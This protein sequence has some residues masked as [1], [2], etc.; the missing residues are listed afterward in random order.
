LPDINPGY[1]ITFNENKKDMSLIALFFIFIFIILIISST[2]I[3][4][5][6]V[7]FITCTFSYIYCHF[8]INGIWPKSGSLL[9]FSK[10]KVQINTFCSD[11]NK[12]AS[13]KRFIAQ[14]SPSSIHNE[15]FIIL[16]LKMQDQQLKGKTWLILKRESM[17]TTDFT[18]LRRMLVALK[19]TQQSEF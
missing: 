1:K 16:R 19:T 17:D 7:S 9:L 3:I 15:R 11:N 6:V 13:D 2:H 14:V 10:D 8:R 5:S 4:S 18:R 12:I